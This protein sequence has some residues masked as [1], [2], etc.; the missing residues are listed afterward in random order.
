MGGK[1][2]A[3]RFFRFWAVSPKAHSL[4]DLQSHRIETF[5]LS[6]DPFFI[7]KLRDVVGLYLSLLDNA[8]GIC[9][10]QKSQR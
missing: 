7:K 1:A 4:F 5:K 10:D 9:I 6:N 8:L 2:G 3:S